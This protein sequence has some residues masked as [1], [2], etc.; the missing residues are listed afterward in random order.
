MWKSI[1]LVLIAMTTFIGG[2]LLWQWKAYS[3]QN[4]LNSESS[5]RAIQEITVYSNE[6]ELQIS[7]KIS[8]LMSGKEYKVSKPDSLFRWSCKDKKGKPCDSGDENPYT[9]KANQNELVFEY[10]IPV[11][12]NGSAFLLNEWVTSIPDLV[13]TSSSIEIIDNAR[14]GGTWIAGAPIKGFKEMDLI[15]YYYFE[16]IGNASSLYWQP[17]PIQMKQSNMEKVFYYGGQGLENMNHIQEMKRLKGIPFVSVVFTDQYRE[18]NGKGIMIVSP[19]TNEDELNQKL[20]NYYFEKKFKDISS[21]QNWIIDV[22]TSYTTN[23]AAK[24]AKGKAIIEELGNKLSEEELN[25]FFKKASESS[26]I[27]T[28]KQ[29]DHYLS[30][31]KGWKSKFFV[32]N[33]ES[34]ESI[35]P[36][37]FYD[38]R[39]VIVSG[40][41]EKDIEVVIEQDKRLFPFVQTMKALGY[42][43]QIL[44]D[45]ETILLAKGSN[46]YRFFL[47]R[48]I[49]IYNEEDYGLLES[50]LLNV[51]GNI[52]MNKEW[53][54]TLFKVNIEVGNEE[55]N[56]SL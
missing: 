41:E 1:L 50:P 37:Y 6:K 45:K 24:T 23:Q 47:N 40:K 49:F 35:I 16:G 12:T 51:N 44:S 22:F 11:Q 55:I 5:E 46:S 2:M 20:I 38:F 25:S 13:I 27:L 8:G 17:K 52:Y 43:V 26:E 39:K 7:Q 15:D 53:I 42:D 32:S 36:L 9:F 10:T 54:E 3:K 56:I 14:R 48:N 29:L 4:D 34:T 33:G 31:L 19:K 30:E 18:E 28:L 21:D